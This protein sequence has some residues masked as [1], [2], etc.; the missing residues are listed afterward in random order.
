MCLNWIKNRI[1]VE[2]CDRDVP[3]PDVVGSI[4]RHSLDPLLKSVLGDI[5]ILYGDNWYRIVTMES[6]KKFLDYDQT[7]KYSYVADKPD[8]D[9]FDCNS[10]SLHLAGN[11]S[12]PGWASAITGP[13][14][15]STP[16]HA[17]NIFVDE[18]LEVWYVEPQTDQMW[19][20][21]DKPQ[22]VPAILWLS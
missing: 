16:N 14:W 11:L 9:R 12:I 8:V 21:T 13:I 18:E 2:Y 3:P 22:W 6:F 10:Y 19:K 7:D 20:V 1:C 15:L 17:V 5:P 4:D